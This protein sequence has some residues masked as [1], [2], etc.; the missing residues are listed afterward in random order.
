MQSLYGCHTTYPYK[1]FIL[2]FKQPLFVKLALFNQTICFFSVI[3]ISLY[4]PKYLYNEAGTWEFNRQDKCLRFATY[5]SKSSQLHV[6]YI[7]IITFFNAHTTRKQHLMMDN[8][9]NYIKRILFF[10]L[11]YF[12]LNLFWR[13]K[14]YY[15]QIRI[16]ISSML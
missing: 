11:C 8:K 10:L 9:V 3:F 4:L 7:V 1:L 15:L 13:R 12:K 2:K 6:S 5:V 16:S 14:W